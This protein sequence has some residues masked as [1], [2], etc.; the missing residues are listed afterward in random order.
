MGFSVLLVFSTNLINCQDLSGPQKR[1]INE[2]L[3]ELISKYENYSRFTSDNR[4][5]NA[6]Y[7]DGFIG[8]FEKNAPVYLDILPSNKVSDVVSIND[9]ISI[10]KKH[11]GKGVGVNVRNILLGKPVHSD[12]GNYTADI[13]LIKE[14][15]GFTKTNVNYSDAVSLV[16]TAGFRLAGN[17][18]DD[19]RILKISGDRIGRFLKFQIR[20]FPTNRPVKNAEIR[21]DSKRTYTDSDGKAV[22]KDINPERKQTLII[23]HELYPQIV[24]SDLDIDQY[25][26]NNT[27]DDQKKLKQDYFDQNEFI[28]SL[29]TL[30]FHVSP[31]M[32]I[33]LPGTKTIVSEG[34]EK[35]PGMGNLEQRA[36]ISPRVGIRA[37]ISLWRTG[38]TDISV[39]MGIEESFIRSAFLFD[40]CIVNSFAGIPVNGETYNQITLYDHTQRITLSLTE[41]PLLVSFSQK[42]NK[43]Y[44]IGANMGVR[45]SFVNS[46]RCR[47]ES[48]LSASSA[49]S[50][51]DTLIT[52]KQK[53]FVTKSKFMSYQFGIT[54]SRQIK[55]SLKI[56]AGPVLLFYQKELLNNENPSNRILSQTGSFNNILYTYN[57]SKLK[58]ISLEFG[59]K[60][61]FSSINFK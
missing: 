1:M 7:E 5:F 30:N 22:I 43:N 34:P 2:A 11:Y 45:F 42:I 50:S 4:T 3:L 37:G 29:N 47:V 52:D 38:G 31:V 17:K 40:T 36:A 23:S 46:S 59:L 35:I 39:A 15:Y 6:E 10:F 32:G 33:S 9:Y 55:P 27:V 26:E 8:L 19:V 14:I 61:S 48:G 20:K 12:G 24:K 56:Y 49:T 41:I 13:E 25:I 51:I 18:I 53:N 60:Y 58:Y 54:L 16:I 57:E 44:E 21:I 28:Y